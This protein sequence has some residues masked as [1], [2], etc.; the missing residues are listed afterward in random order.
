M[1][2]FKEELRE[3]LR[4]RSVLSPAGYFVRSIEKHLSHPIVVIHTTVCKPGEHDK[5]IQEAM[6][7]LELLPDD[8]TSS[9]YDRLRAENLAN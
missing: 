1:G 2:F 4:V 9:D 8:A 5:E 3:L 6:R 7:L